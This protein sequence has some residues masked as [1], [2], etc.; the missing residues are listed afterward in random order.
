MVILIKYPGPAWASV[1]SRAL[2]LRSRDAYKNASRSPRSNPDQVM[3]RL[4]LG[5]AGKPP[6]RPTGGPSDLS[7]K[8]PKSARSG[9]PVGD[10]KEK[11]DA[12]PPEGDATPGISRLRRQQPRNRS[13]PRKR[14]R[15]RT[16]PDT[17]VCAPV[18]PARG[19]RRRLRS[20]LLKIWSSI[21]YLILIAIFVWRAASG[22]K[23]IRTARR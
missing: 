17:H 3:S 4:G 20:L 9:P 18:R 5:R 22:L 8:N 23:S 10:K 12:T 1:S 14:R 7:Q 6:T 15:I 11:P 21:C 2:R 19:P 13:T 16:D